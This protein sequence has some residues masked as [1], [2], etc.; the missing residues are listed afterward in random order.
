LNLK[1]R[2]ASLRLFPKLVLTFLF[3][4][5]PLYIIGTL[6]NESGS[7]NIQQE[8]ASSLSSRVDLY[9]EMID[10]D[11]YRVYQ[12]LQQYVNDEDLQNLSVKAEIMTDFDRTQA[13]LRLK[14][15]LD[16]LKQSSVF[17]ENVSVMIPLLHRTISSND[18]SIAEFD[19]SQ[20]EALRLA[21]SR[22]ESPFMVW[23]DRIFISMAYPDASTKRRPVFLLL[24]E[25]SRS[26]LT[27]AL[28]RF[29]TKGG[30]AVLAGKSIDWAVVGTAGASEHRDL[31][32]SV[33]GRAA[34]ALR[35][36]DIGKRAYLAATKPSE[37]F[38]MS[39]TMFVPAEQVN[40][41]VLTYRKWLIALS[42]A[43]AAIAVLFSY[44][45]YRLI[46]QP[47]R[48]LMHTFR[49]VEQGQLNQTVAYPFKDEF[50]YLYDQFNAMIRQLNVLVHE[51]YEQQYRAK[52]SEL[53]H[54]QS[55]INPHFLYNTYYILYR[56]AKREDNENLLRL[57]KHLGDYF[58]YITRDAADEVPFAKEA[59]H[60]RTYMEIQSIRF[61]GR[62]E[63]SFDE[64]PE[65]AEQLPVPRLLLQPII[66]N[67]Y[68]H[69]LEKMSRGGWLHVGI[70][71][72]PE[73]LIVTVEDNG[74]G[75]TQE[76][77]DELQLA[78]RTYDAAREST[79]M[80]NVHR[81]L[82][83]KYGERSGLRLTAG[84]R[85]GLRVELVIPRGE[86][87]EHA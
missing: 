53:R 42:A 59:H 86:E 27:S 21:P 75:L 67:A 20:F 70:T 14:R 37:R 15:R 8:I 57:T 62:V 30:G 71:L 83:I 13:I 33:D 11:L 84:G 64:L 3:V 68:Q 46:H 4:L 66:E 41:P 73:E 50:G 63:T 32:E 82:R 2:I 47:L 74:E 61:G 24:I 40:A 36:V 22:L 49:R 52:L 29:T 60:A 55:Q 65:G 23:Q 34:G 44:S 7:R 43:S 85:G 76:K 16:L 17:V 45:L 25:I 12:L 56:M 77:L 81:R 9:M 31:F 18:E 1:T 19:S 28:A 80:L 51:V 79:G 38:G 69:A 78:L 35:E 58:Q 26:E 72:R 39:L 54:L 87:N 5:S 48:A 6:M 10:N